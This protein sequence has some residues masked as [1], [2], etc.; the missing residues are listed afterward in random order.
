MKTPSD[1]PSRS[2]KALR[3]LMPAFQVGGVNP[4][5][6][7]QL[8]PGAGHDDLTRGHHVTPV[9]QTQGV[10]GILLDQEDGDALLLVDLP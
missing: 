5:V 9:R 1:D 10:I 3:S 2:S 4:R 8:G 6:G 7:Q